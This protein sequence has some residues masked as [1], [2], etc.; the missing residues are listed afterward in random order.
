[1]IDFPSILAP[2]I[3]P[4]SIKKV[5]KNQSKNLSNFESIFFR[6]L[7]HLAR[8][9]GPQRGSTKGPRTN[10]LRSFWLLEPRW[11]PDPP[12][13]AP[14]FN[15]HRSFIDFSSIF[16]RFSSTLEVQD[17]PPGYLGRH[18]GRR[19]PAGR[20]W[21]IL[22]RCWRILTPPHCPRTR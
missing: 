13:M 20:C 2:Q 22:E 12:K 11:L 8:F 15:F 14:G 1:M 21:G 17:D 10:F 6:F 3:A 19:G 5:I 7:T 9:E 16:H 18:L 4:K